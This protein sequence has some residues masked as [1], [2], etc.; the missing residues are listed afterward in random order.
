MKNRTGFGWLELVLGILMIILGIL[1]FVWPKGA[2]TSMV[3]LY[4]TAAI[5]TGIC[6][7]LFYIRMDQY[8]GFGPIVALISGIISVMTGMMLIIYP[9]VGEW[10]VYFLFPIWFIA[11]NVFN[12]ATLKTLRM[13]AGDF[14]Y[15]FTLIASI[16]GLILGWLMVLW[17]FG[18]IRSVSIII[19]FY[20]I[21][22]GI[23]CIVIA[24]G[25]AGRM[26]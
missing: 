13:A 6:D 7:I 10:I 20:L 25:G 21:L 5:I 1:S 22:T 8:T 24:L 23:N 12:L 14:C 11:H 16:V 9:D 17:S 3:M 19:G 18:S 4:A 26:R 15:Y 2:M